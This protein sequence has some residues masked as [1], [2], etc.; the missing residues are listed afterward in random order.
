ME[1]ILLWVV[2]AQLLQEEAV[3]QKTA[4]Y[5]SE[6]LKDDASLRAQENDS[7]V[8]IGPGG[9]VHGNAS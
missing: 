5:F 3:I 7:V 1:Y 8:A 9:V 2:D 4:A 6:E